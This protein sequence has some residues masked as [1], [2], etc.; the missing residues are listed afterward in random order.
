M[1]LTSQLIKTHKDFDTFSRDLIETKDVDPVYE[2]I[3]K[4]CETFGFEPIWFT[5]VYV[6]F[7][8]LKSAIH[9]CKQ[10]KNA[11]D[12]NKALFAKLKDD[13]RITFG[14]ERRGTGRQTATMI[15]MFNVI[16]NMIKKSIV[17]ELNFESNF[18][19]RESIQRI[20]NHGRWAAFKIAEIFEKSFGFETLAINDLGLTPEGINQNSSPSG[21]LKWLYGKT[22]DTDLD[23]TPNMIPT[24]NH[25]ADDLSDAWG[26][27]IGKVETCLCKFHKLV[28]GKY[29]VGHDIQEF[30]EFRHGRFID[31]MT[32]SQFDSI[33]ESCSFPE[34]IWKDRN[35]MEIENKNFYQKTKKLK[36]RPDIHTSTWKSANIS[37]LVLKNKI[38]LS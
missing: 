24:F 28:T 36:T 26:Y 18:L 17:D 37:K 20:P 21:G 38:E 33:M 29:Y 15:A 6:G 1:K 9:V 34:W 3:P 10:M 32:K 8:D 5:F 35:R 31:L 22:E 23:F 11:D 25:L 30:L 12:W 14:H 16:S 7:Y 13:G 2:V 27:D 4:I 19:L